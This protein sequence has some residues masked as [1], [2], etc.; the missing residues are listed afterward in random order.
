MILVSVLNNPNFD[1][2]TCIPVFGG[3]LIKTVNFTLLGQG[4]PGHEEHV[5][6]VDTMTNT[7]VYNLA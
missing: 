2:H 4:D 6:I 7:L 3:V 5:C 1:K